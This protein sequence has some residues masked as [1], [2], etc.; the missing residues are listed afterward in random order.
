MMLTEMVNW[1]R[2]TLRNAATFVFLLLMGTLDSP[3]ARTETLV[4]AIAAKYPTVFS[5]EGLST[6]SSIFVKWERSVRLMK[7][8]FFVLSRQYRVH[9]GVHGC[10]CPR[11]EAYL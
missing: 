3:E 11:R 4:H 2:M 10:Q 9:H 1:E 6:V 5:E 8:A 7:Q